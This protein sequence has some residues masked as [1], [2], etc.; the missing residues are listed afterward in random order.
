M[1]ITVDRGGAAI[2]AYDI[3]DKLQFA[4]ESL[5]YNNYTGMDPYHLNP[6]TKP[7]MLFPPSLLVVE[8]LLKM[9]ASPSPDLTLWKT[10][11]TYMHQTSIAAANARHEL[12]EEP[13]LRGYQAA[14]VRFMRLQ[15]RVLLNDDLGLGK[16]IEALVAARPTIRNKNALVLAP[17][18]LATQWC[19][20][21][22]EWV[23]GTII[24][25]LS[26]PKDRK[27][28]YA[29]HKQKNFVVV[30]NWDAITS[31]K[32]I[33]E[34]VEWGCIIGDESHLLK[35]RN[36]QRYQ[37]MKGLAENC[38]YLF[39]LTGTPIEKHP[40]ELWT[41]LHLLYP[42]IFTSYWS[43]YTTFV[44]YALEFSGGL[45]INGPK[46]TDV[47][48]DILRPLQ[49]R[50]T[51]QQELKD[52]KEPIMIPVT[53]NLTDK[54]QKLY[55]AIT[56][57]IEIDLTKL[58]YKADSIP[59]GQLLA[60]SALQQINLWRQVALSEEMV[61]GEKHTSSAKIETLQGLLDSL[62]NENV[63]IFTSYRRMVDIVHKKL[64]AQA[65]RFC[66][67]DDP[68]TIKNFGSKY[69]YLVATPQ[70]IGA[71]FNLQVARIIIFMDI[72]NSS[73]LFKQCIGRVVR[74]GQEGQ[75]LIYLM[76]A[77][78]TYDIALR[79]LINSKEA[80]FNE[81]IVARKYLEMKT[82]RLYQNLTIQQLGAQR[83]M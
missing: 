18:G 2:R 7:K 16:S 49:L 68:T 37:N 36:T 3:N 30:A 45:K 11:V 70:S 44:D 55:D 25:N 51:R 41:Q 61:V 52:V 38:E 32:S 42:K 83:L 39:L 59:Q 34:S 31:S 78:N 5:S 79:E 82:N 57:K 54:Q 64:G 40:A 62:E 22:K 1:K 63:V 67:G 12:K 48:Y 33:F 13:R 15:K 26:N 77:E 9:G 65:M 75:P 76:Y 74:F 8:R 66:G 4:M 72:P 73:I 81:V 46:N 35:N 47:L 58:G 43:F 53:V 21:I 29:F 6:Y 14:A 50:R 69:S 71:G 20:Y 19:E 60:E 10:A 56:D 80:T 23:P 17:K 27:R 24:Y 28:E